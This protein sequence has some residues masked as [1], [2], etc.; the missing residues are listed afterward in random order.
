MNNVDQF[1]EVKVGGEK[2]TTT[3]DRITKTQTGVYIVGR[4]VNEHIRQV[5]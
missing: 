3:A 4:I 1:Q 5:R 2:H